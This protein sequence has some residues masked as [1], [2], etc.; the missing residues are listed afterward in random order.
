MD[1]SA[2]VLSTIANKGGTSLSFHRWK[3]SH[4]GRLMEVK[5]KNILD[6]FYHDSKCKNGNFPLYVGFTLLFDSVNTAQANGLL[7]WYF[8]LLMC[9]GRQVGKYLVCHLEGK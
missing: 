5:N 6:S 1:A 9:S 8:L 2:I 7:F 3:C 4:R